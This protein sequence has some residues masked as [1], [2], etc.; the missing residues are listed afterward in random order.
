MLADD[1]ERVAARDR[2]LIAVAARFDRGTA[3]TAME[4]EYMIV[5]ARKQS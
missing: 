3:A 2:A 1:P 5:T 4:W